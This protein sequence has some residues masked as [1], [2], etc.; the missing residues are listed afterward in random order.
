[1]I[2]WP[3]DSQG[4]SSPASWPARDGD[5][6][7]VSGDQMAALESQLLASSL[8]V[9][10]LKEKAALA[11]SRRLLDGHLSGPGLRVSGAADPEGIPVL[12]GPWHNGGDG[13]VVARELHLA[14]CPCGCGAPSSGASPLRS[15]T[16]ATPSGW[17]SPFSGKHLIRRI[18]A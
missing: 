14:G 18:R 5:H 12:V 16:G 15:A 3:H 13:L 4:G 11:L 2:G 8:P 6:L 7:L 9:E 1:M 10:A 17:E